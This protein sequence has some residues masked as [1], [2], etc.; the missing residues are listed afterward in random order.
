[1]PDD[2]F[3]ITVGEN[4]CSI[5]LWAYKAFGLNSKSGSQESNSSSPVNL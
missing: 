1:M 4:D 5:M 2:S 3:L